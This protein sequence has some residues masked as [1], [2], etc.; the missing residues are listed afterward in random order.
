MSTPTDKPL[1]LVLSPEQSAALADNA[2]FSFVVVGPGSWPDTP[3]RMVLYLIETDCKRA[4]A[5]VRVARGISTERRIR[6]PKAS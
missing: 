6:T 1:R 5:A 4:D 2:R 3:G